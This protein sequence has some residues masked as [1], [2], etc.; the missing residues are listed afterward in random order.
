MSSLSATAQVNYPRVFERY[1]ATVPRVP[2]HEDYGGRD[3]AVADP[4]GN[5]RSFGTDRESEPNPGLGGTPATP[6]P[7]LPPQGL[8]ARL[9]AQGQPAEDG[10]GGPQPSSAHSRELP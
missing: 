5:Q 8:P 4:E 9:T 7:D 3:F 2:R 10:C 1:G 6:A